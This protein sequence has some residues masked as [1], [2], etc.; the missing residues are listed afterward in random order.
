MFIQER[1]FRK[2]FALKNLPYV[3]VCMLNIAP[4]ASSAQRKDKGRHQYRK[5]GALSLQTLFFSQRQEC[6]I[7]LSSSEEA[8][9]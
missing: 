9:K 6:S 7:E 5:K 1:I 8:G 4:I 2:R 3:T